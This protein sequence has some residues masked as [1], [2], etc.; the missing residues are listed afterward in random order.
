MLPRH[1]RLHVSKPPLTTLGGARNQIRPSLDAGN[2]QA[3]T[4]SFFFFVS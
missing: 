1:A 2:K 4:L 3:N